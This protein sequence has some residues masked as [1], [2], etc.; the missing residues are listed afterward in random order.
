MRGHLKERSPGHW[1]IVLDI[2]DPQT[3]KRRRK[4]HSFK[5]TKRQAQ[6]ECARLVA[7]QSD[8]GYIEPAKI[9]VADFLTRWLDYKKSRLSPLSFERYGNVCRVNIIPHIGNIR[10]AKLQS[11][12]VTGLYATLLE[13][14]SAHAT[15]YAHRVLRQALRQGM[16]WKMLSS[17]VTD[18]VERPKAEKHQMRALDASGIAALLEAS[19]DT[20]MFVPIL[21]AIS[22]GMRRGE[23]CALRWRN[24]DLD[25]ASISVVAS[26]EQT[27]N[28]IREKAPKNGKSRTIAL[29][30]MLVAELRQHRARQAVHLLRHGIRLSPDHHVAM[31]QNG[32]SLRPRSV[33]VMFVQM[34]NESPSLQRIRFHDLRH[35]A[36]T[37]L[38]GAGVNVKVVSEMLGHHSAAFTL[39]VYGHVLRGMQEQAAQKMDEVMRAA[40]AR[41]SK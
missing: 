39:D 30:A 21:I 38:L 14:L 13:T 6:V 12:H 28:S 15:A 11:L 2:A 9:T 37:T 3:G 35:S 29:P 34:L 26:V 7:Q 33:S 31:K 4:W 19:R 10:L 5:G 23:I 17:N 22:T 27:A 41:R 1:A 32:E 25:N 8:G 18:D 24:V 36:A 20:S 16:R 40:L